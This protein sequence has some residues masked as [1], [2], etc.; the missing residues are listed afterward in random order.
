MYNTKG[1]DSPHFAG[2]AEVRRVAP[3]EES[4]DMLRTAVGCLEEN[5]GALNNRLTPVMGTP[6]PV[7]HVSEKPPGFGVPLADTIQQI[8]GRLGALNYQARE[9]LDRLGV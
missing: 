8:T 1:L 3:I 7:N 2:A 9:L 6:M 5:I 4:I